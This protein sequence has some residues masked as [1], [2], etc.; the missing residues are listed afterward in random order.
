MF[1]TIYLRVLDF[2]RNSSATE[3]TDAQAPDSSTKGPIVQ[4]A[5]F[6]DG[7]LT[8]QCARTTELEYIAISH[9]WGETGWLRIP[10]VDGE[11][12]ASRS[13]AEFIEK[14]LPALVGESVFWMDTL[15]VNQ[16]NQAEVIATVQVIPTI[17][18]DAT[19]TIA[20]RESDVQ[21]NLRN[22]KELLC[23]RTFTENQTEI[24]RVSDS[25]F[26]LAHSFIG[27]Q[28]LKGIE[29]FIRAYVDGGTI[30]RSKPLERDDTE[31]IHTGTFRAVQLASNRSASKPRDYIFATMPQFPWYHYPAGAE[32]MSFGDIFVDL[33]EQ[34]SRAG[35]ASAC[36]IT[37]SM[38]DL[39]ANA[40]PNNAWLSSAQQPEPACLG[41]FLKLLGQRLP[42]KTPGDPD[43]VH[44][45][46]VVYVVELTGQPPNTV[47]GVIESAMR[48][49]QMVWQTS[50]KGG[51]LSKYGSFPS[52]SWELNI[53]DAACSGW[54][55]KG[56]PLSQPRVRL[57]QDGDETLMVVGTHMEWEEDELMAMILGY[58]EGEGEL[59]P[60]ITLLEQSRKILDHMWCGMED[61][62]HNK[63]QAS[64]WDCFKREMRGS[65]S[66]PL[67]R[68]ILL[69]AAMVSCRI[70]LSAASWMRK[71]FIPVCVRY[72]KVIVLGLL[73]KHA[74]DTNG[75]GVRR[76]YSVGQ[77]PKGNSFGKGL[78]LVDPVAKYRWDYCLTSCLIYGPTTNLW[79][80]QVHF[81]KTS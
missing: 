13:K 30:V 34:A 21:A 10:N 73:A 42:S 12:L 20:I 47:I 7:H 76:M 52:S 26:V 68:T 66:E 67:L 49:S 6:V 15:T 75:L 2:F 35:H 74:R 45:T 54:I 33:Y 79:S 80:E 36:R 46:T 57:I 77:H 72:K 17:F 38:T 60:Y 61:I 32:Q 1:R 56:P 81:M 50:H 31:D 51:E 78:V 71:R 43:N 24:E 55:L 23:N 11:V 4:F 63:A 39:E 62:T 37:R 14:K 70:G 40:D 8:L 28:G 59:A 25:L 27:D 22:S 69:L 58:S 16:K 53:L 65:W 64:D 3:H 18:R 44:L 9:V 5:R 19:R 48:F 29:S 41:D